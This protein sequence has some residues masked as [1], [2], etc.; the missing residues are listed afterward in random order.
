VGRRGGG[1]RKEEHGDN[2]DE[3]SNLSPSSALSRV[4]SRPSTDSSEHIRR[5]LSRRPP[6]SLEGCWDALLFGTPAVTQNVEC[7]GGGANVD[8]VSGRRGLVWRWPTNGRACLQVNKA[9]VKTR[10]RFIQL[11]SACL[12]VCVSVLHARVLPAVREGLQ[13]H[14][15]TPSTKIPRRRRT[16]SRRSADRFRRVLR[17]PHRRWKMWSRD[18]TT[19]VQTP[20]PTVRLLLVALRGAAFCRTSMHRWCVDLTIG[21][22]LANPAILPPLEPKPPLGW[23]KERLFRTYFRTCVSRRIEIT[24]WL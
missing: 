16:P 15:T 8:V 21:Q 7:G 6:S 10:Q 24:I 13:T 9:K 23:L 18:H 17:L 2:E 5:F 14:Q 4:R 22:P 3:G 11:C 1:G 12:K 20:P 19:T